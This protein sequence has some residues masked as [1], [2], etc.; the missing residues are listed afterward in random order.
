MTTF[1]PALAP[2]LAAHGISQRQLARAAGLS[3][4]AVNAIAARGQW[5]KRG[6]AAARAA[7][8]AALRRA[9]ASTHELRAL[10]LP[11]PQEVGPAGLPPGEAVSPETNQDKENESMLHRETITPAARQA[12]GLPRSLLAL[13]DVQCAE[14]VFSTPHTRYVRAALLDAA[15]HAGFAAVLG[16][17]GSGKTTLAEDLQERLEQEQRKVIVIKPYPRQPRRGG[18]KVLQPG[19]IEAALLR[20]LALGATRAS[21][22]DDRTAQ[23]HELLKSSRASGYAHLLL[24][25]EAHRLPVDTL[26]QLKNFMELKD[27]R[28]RLLGVVLIGQAREMRALLNDR[29]PEVREIV[30]R[31]EQI[32]LGALDAD[33][34]DYV[35]HK[36]ARAGVKLAD[37]LAADAVEAI[38]ARLISVPRGGKASDAISVCHPLAVNNLLARAFN[39]AAAV[40][41]AKVDAQVVAGC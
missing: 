34:G 35:A 14:D 27:R 8:L 25:E 28:R 5:P 41:Y 36:L 39:A 32:T 16:E 37:V 31:C 9:G 18:G 20:A 22:P 30:Q 7:V 29:D 2:V 13:D 23:I 12:F 6:T 24:M 4:A 40:G 17:S 11:A 33:L 15:L 26:K 38:R 1:A 19:Q 21:D 3:V 10:A